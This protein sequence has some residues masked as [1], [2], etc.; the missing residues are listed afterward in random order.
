MLLSVNAATL[1][2]PRFVPGNQWTYLATN[3]QGQSGTLTQT[4]IGPAT[5]NG[6]SATEIDTTVSTGSAV[7]QNYEGFD[8]A[9]DAVVFG[10]MV[11]GT[12]TTQT[13]I[14]S[15]YRGSFVA[16]MV[17]GVTYDFT[18][19]DTP[20]STIGGTTT[21]GT[22]SDED[23][24]LTLLSET[25]APL[26]V[27]AG[28]FNVYQGQE[29][30]TTT[31]P[32]PSGPPT[33]TT[34]TTSIWYAPGLGIVKIV[35]S[36][37]ITDV[38]T[39]YKVAGDHLVFT[40][41]PTDTDPGTTIQ[42]SIT[43]AAENNSNNVDTTAGGSI[44]IS[45]G[46][47]TGTGTLSG[48]LTEPLVNG[49][50]TF[51]DLKIDSGGTYTLTASD[52]VTPP[53]SPVTSN[54]FNVSGTALTWTGAGDGVNWSDPKNWDQNVKPVNGDSL[55]FPAGSPLTSNNDIAG[56]SINSIDLQGSGY[57]LTGNVI[58]L[59]GG[60]TSEAGNNTFNIDT[61][62]VGSPTLDDQTGDLTIASVLSGDG[63]TVAGNGIFTFD[64]TD[65]YTGATTLSAGVTIDDN[66]LTDA[67]STG[68]LTIGAG[69]SAV[70]IADTGSGSATLDNAI[71][72][73]DGSTLA[74]DPQ[75]ILGGTVTV[76]GKDTVDSIN[77]GDQLTLNSSKP[78]AGSG[79]VTIVGGGKVLVQDSLPA[80]I[81]FVVVSGELDLDGNL[82]GAVSDT[83]QVTV[84]GGTVQLLSNLSGFGG[85]DVKTGTL[86]SSIDASA[87]GG[88]VT[89]EA[90]YPLPTRVVLTP[91]NNVLGV[92]D[93]VVAPSIATDGIYFPTI[94]T[95]ASQQL[96]T[97]TNPVTF[98]S[99]GGLT[100][101][102]AVTFS[103]A[104]TLSGPASLFTSASSDQLTLSSGIQGS[105]TLTLGGPGTVEVDGT[106]AAEVTLNANDSATG[107]QASPTK[108]N[109]GATLMGPV[110][111]ASQVV[112]DCA[113]TILQEISGSGGIELQGGTLRTA[114][115]L[116]YSG[117]LTIDSYYF[118]YGQKNIPDVV[119]TSAAFPLGIGPLLVQS[120]NFNEFGGVVGAPLLDA[121]ALAQGV[122]LSNAMMLQNNG[123]LKTAGA[124][125]FAD[126]VSVSGSVAL[127]PGN[128]DG[129]NLVIKNGIQG[130]G[131]LEF[132]FGNVTV[133]GSVAAGVS[134]LDQSAPMAMMS[135][136]ANL[137]GA[138][139]GIPQVTVSTNGDTSSI[140]Q[141]MPGLSGTG[142]I[143]VAAGTLQSA[144]TTTY[145]GTITLEPVQFS[146]GGG[147]HYWVSAQVVLGPSVDPL[148]TGQLILNPGSSPSGSG[149]VTLDAS[150]APLGLALSNPVTFQGSGEVDTLGSVTF[151]GLATIAVPTA[152]LR[153]TSSSAE[154]DF[155]GGIQGTGTLILGGFGTTTVTG[156]VAAGVGLQAG[157]SSAGT[158][159]IDTNLLNLGANLMGAAGASQVTEL[160]STLH[161]LRSLEGTGGIDMRGGTLQSDGLPFYSGTVTLEAGS[162][163]PDV[164]LLSGAAPLG[165]GPL[166]MAT[167]RNASLNPPLIDASGLPQ[168]V[169][170]NNPLNVQPG[171]VLNIAGLVNFSGV[172]T[173]VSAVGFA[174][175]D[176]TDQLT[177]SGTLQ[178]VG[179]ITV[180][181]PGTTTITTTGTIPGSIA[182]Y[183]AD[184]LTGT[185]EMGASLFGVSGG[186]NQVTVSAGVVSLLSTTSGS[187]NIS[188]T[189]GTLI[190]T[191]V[192]GYNGVITVSTGGTVK[193]YDGADAMGLGTGEID[194]NGGLLQ[195]STGGAAVIG[196]P[197][198]VGG[199]S[200]ISGGTRLKFS[201]TFNASNGPLNLFGTV[202][203]TGG[204]TGGASL[205]LQGDA[206]EV[207]GSNP[208]FTGNVVWISGIVDVT[209][210]NALGTGLV[211]AK[212][213]AQGVL[214][215][216][217][218]GDPV[219]ENPLVVQT[220][221]LVLEGQFT[222]PN[223][224]TVDS[225]ATLEISGAGSQVV[226][227]GPLSGGGTIV[228][229]GGT[230]STPGGSS[231]FTGSVQF[232]GG[233]L[234]PNLTVT[235]A[236]GTF[237]GS[238]FPAAASLSAP[239]VSATGSLQ[240]VT[241]T[242]TYYVGTSTTA[243]GSTTA[244]ANP[245]TYTVVAS[246]AGSADYTAVQSSPVTFV[247]APA[248]DKLVF[249]VQPH[250]SKAGKLDPVIVLIENS[251][252]Q[253]VFSDNSL[254]TLSVYSGPG[255]LEG[256][257]SVMAH[258][259]VVIF[260]HVSL[261]AAG[262]YMLEA[263][264]GNDKPA[265]SRGF[266]ILPHK[267]HR[268]HFHDVDEVRS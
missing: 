64:Q 201:N 136:A 267:H 239:G 60:L 182:F 186:P 38:L 141:L 6:I 170:L 113:L 139:G 262:T 127:I 162:P 91:G 76:N 157:Q 213:A 219:L 143:D 48:T 154:A 169:I 152:F 252:G 226:D 63:L 21:T 28:T 67:F 93:L 122:N 73:Q 160:N 222:F 187:G 228:L 107:L 205:V 199:T 70:T 85:I 66:V 35:S 168:G 31:T 215:S 118:G 263:T 68:A 45:L 241:P 130:T 111:G 220:G 92:G 54:Q 96:E 24:K 144:V 133:S 32:N 75:V 112:S 94:N 129:D 61:T 72:F 231:A 20:T 225:G 166:A 16:N 261:A 196:N 119:L 51:S 260:D 227:S 105:G 248:Q 164:V 200:T 62:L 171:A 108:F 161:L 8:G 234:T 247:I 206:L 221:T 87:Y 167:P 232:Q 175:S 163:S 82:Q 88:T 254:V 209:Q 80:T 236:G 44:T 81:Q 78:L 115:A 238:P 84:K 56:L 65:T 180:D 86:I 185:L 259:G 176:A 151:A 178:G 229:G 214:N 95:S 52:S 34:S 1:L 210:S 33:I 198:V 11:T 179:S 223:G 36:D 40:Q 15:P 83:G 146:L 120:P 103:N 243:T 237:T 46:T 74:V 197:I 192:A 98:Q 37:G 53:V 116:K 22:V 224:I 14:Y 177:F 50:A 217:A 250:D 165:T 195:N 5:F 158:S 265:I 109:L 117:T 138:L 244:P 207:A 114:G 251:N 193:D 12:N 135:L 216:D 13:D 123:T 191:G 150:A 172:I 25:L 2:A 255:T 155:T 124:V 4:V 181:G 126:T 42:P 10:N 55:I 102:G 203:I 183:T 47:V 23:H 246:F 128:S 9:G 69:A 140:L 245:G 266:R 256:K 204:L 142:G 27:P 19:T 194:L 77:P 137:L 79:T 89:L 148:G 71:T 188:V 212:L 264:S 145:S 258:H 39:Q 235:D 218:I 26:T 174:A 202:A 230:F 242:L 253:I 30:Q 90:S 173:V 100:V 3:A 132:N 208:N 153:T 125:T 147:G 233:T 41:Q 184:T 240:G 110:G 49:V 104:P 149:I 131:T 249:L 101:T 121:S 29:V 57:D 257:V 189:G 190:S 59:T 106:V 268:I 156:D 58:S 43:V 159:G 211:Q 7:S 99:G 97:L 17:G 134:L 18:N